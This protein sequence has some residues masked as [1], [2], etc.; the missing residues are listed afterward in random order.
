MKFLLKYIAVWVLYVSVLQTHG[1]DVQYSQFYGSNILMNPAFA[2]ATKFARVT[3]FQRMQWP[4]ISGKTISSAVAFDRYFYDY[5]I[6]LGGSLQ[7]DRLASG[8]LNNISVGPSVSY[9][10][11][12]TQKQFL[13]LGL[14][15]NYVNKRYTTQSL[16]FADQLDANFGQILSQSTDTYAQTNYSKSYLDLNMGALYNTKNFWIGASVS[17]LNKPVQS[18]EANSIKTPRKIHIH[19]GYKFIFKDQRGL[20]IQKESHLSLAA[21][22]KN[23]GTATQA[24]L[25]V[26]YVKNMFCVGLW[27]RGIPLINSKNGYINQDALTPLIGFENRGFRIGYSYD[28]TISKLGYQTGGSH[29]LSM[30]W[31]FGDVSDKRKKK[32]GKMKTMYMP[33]PKL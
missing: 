9:L 19:T 22:V 15:A 12:N 6:G 2:G 18:L 32:P 11:L 29:E 33:Y 3:A 27:Y 24:D 30:T 14:G 23:Q 5:K 31:D 25:G 8:I 20:A 28:I 16:V 26:Y 17:H 13:R 4:N 21:N 10:V 7:Y 1:Q